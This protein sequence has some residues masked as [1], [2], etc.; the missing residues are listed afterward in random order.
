M[1]SHELLDGLLAPSLEGGY[2]E[3]SVI[4]LYLR[5][6]FELGRAQIYD[7]FYERTQDILDCLPESKQK[8]EF[9][10]AAWRIGPVEHWAHWAGVMPPASKKAKAGALGPALAPRVAD[11][12]DHMIRRAAGL[13]PSATR[14]VI[15][16]LDPLRPA[17]ASLASGAEVERLAGATR[18]AFEA[19]EWWGSEQAADSQAALHE[20]IRAIENASPGASGALR[21]VRADDIRRA[22]LEEAEPVRA[23][24]ALAHDLP[25][26]TYDELQESLPRPDPAEQPLLYAEVVVARI[27]LH[28]CDPNVNGGFSMV[29]VHLKEIKTLRDM[30]VEY[31]RQRRLAGV[32]CLDLQPTPAQLASLSVYLGS[33]PGDDAME[34][35]GRWARQADRTQLANALSRII[36]PQFDAT[37]WAD[38]LSAG[39]YAEAPVIR[40]LR[41]SMGKDRKTT[42]EERRRMALIVGALQIR[43]QSARNNVAD[44]IVLML[45]KDR[46]KSDLGV[47]LI[48]AKGLGPDHHCQAKL[49]RA[50]NAYASRTSHKFKPD[51]YRSIV[52]L[53]ITIPE[54]HLS[55]KAEKGR[56]EI[57]EAAVKGGVKQLGKKLA[58]M[59][60]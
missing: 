48:L 6:L 56:K 1:N 19:H 15:E 45:R 41:E 53:G 34:A 43:T 18:E 20:L 24:L 2:S 37:R 47:A 12:V 54:K 31:W 10:L 36:R 46:P 49:E 9:I 60:K 8:A 22:P 35:L 33:N 40:A 39:D 16:H 59:G 30:G 38:V 57:I 14:S 27:T 21:H 44:L 26:E 7:Y 51:E 32:G 23:M 13:E 11:L 55:K 28:R 29:R 58:G 4:D 52:Q 42:I 5:R 3:A 17:L 50:F 25:D